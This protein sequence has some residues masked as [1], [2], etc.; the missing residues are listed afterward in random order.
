MK[1]QLVAVRLEGVSRLAVDLG[2]LLGLGLLSQRQL[3]ALV[4]RG[5]LCLSAL[6]KSIIDKSV[7]FV[8]RNSSG[9]CSREVT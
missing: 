5:T 7:Q 6:L 8:L 3:L 1:K 9:L 2:V 4:V